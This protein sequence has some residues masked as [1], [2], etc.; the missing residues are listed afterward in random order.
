MAASMRQL[1]WVANRIVGARNM[2]ALPQKSPLSSSEELM[3]LEKQCSVH[4]YYPIPMKG[5]LLALEPSFYNDKFP[6]F[7]EHLTQM[8]GYEMMLPMNPGAEGVETALK[9]ERG[10]LAKPTHRLA[11]PLS[12]SFEELNIASTAFSDVLEIDLPKMAEAKAKNGFRL[13]SSSPLRLKNSSGTA[14]FPRIRVEESP[15]PLSFFDADPGTGCLFRSVGGE[16]I[17]FPS[18][19]LRQISGSVSIGKGSDPMAPPGSP[20]AAVDL[21]S[22]RGDAEEDEGID[23]L[24]RLPD[25]VLLVVFDRIGDVKTLGRCC[26]VCRRFH[27][28]V[29]LVDSVLVR[30]DCVISDDPSPSPA[31]GTGAD[32]SRGVL[33]HLARIVIGGI[34][35]PLQALGHILVP[36]VAVA[37]NRRSSPSS[38]SSSPSS[39]RSSEISHHSPAEVLKNFKEIRRLRIEL[40]AGELGVDD[41]VLLKWKAEFGSTLDSCVILGASSVLSSSS[42]LPKSSSPNPNP[43]FQDPCGAD[44]SGTMPD[45]F[46]TSGNLKLRV[47]WTISSLIAASARHYLLQPIIA[48]HEALERLELTDVDEQGVLTMDRWQ[49]Q[50][51]RAKPLS[52]SGSSQRTLVP[53]LSM[54]LWYAPYL[55]LPGGM[56]LKGATLVVV[57]PTQEPGMDVAS[58]GEFGGVVEF[59]DRCSI[60]SAFEEPYRSAAGML[61]KRRTYCLEMNSF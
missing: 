12:I 60:S 36:S 51:F 13:D 48:D 27:D 32:R 1:Q 58:S 38:P 59:S 3:R 5:Y 18:I 47:F 41:G 11:L 55:E 33:S 28:L 8:F 23:H 9:L 52:A 46:Y 53:A 22:W 16:L 24:D 2:C 6:T 35:K 56:V 54:W 14:E 17:S 49:L 25:S 29:P 15:L 43:S 44:D 34:V 61:V 4:N 40:P 39:S 57:R 31:G 7:A 42:I 21:R 26:V 37:S 19:A 45:S 20:A 10:I 50:E 30:V